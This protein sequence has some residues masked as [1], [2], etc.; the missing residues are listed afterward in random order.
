MQVP[1]LPV[2]RGAVH[3]QYR[4]MQQWDASEFF[5]FW[6]EQARGVEREAGR[7]AHAW[8]HGVLERGGGAGATHW[9]RICT[10]VVE[11]RRQCLGCQRCRVRHEAAEMFSVRPGPAGA[12][13]L[14]TSEMYLRECGPRETQE[15]DRVECDVCQSRQLHREQTRICVAPNVLVLRVVRSVEGGVGGVLARGPVDVEEEMQLPGFPRMVLA[16]V[17]YHSGRTVC[18]GHYTCL[19]RGPGGHYWMYDDRRVT[20]VA[21]EVGHVKSAQVHL[22]VY[23]RADGSATWEGSRSGGHGAGAPGDPEGGVVVV[24]DDVGGGSGAGVA[25]Q[26]GRTARDGT[27]DVAEVMESEIARGGA[28]VVQRRASGGG[29][30]A[31]AVAGRQGGFS[32]ASVSAV[33]SRVCGHGEHGARPGSAEGGGARSDAGLGRARGSAVWKRGRDADPVQEPRRASARL[34]ARQATGPVA[35]EVGGVDRFLRPRGRAVVTSAASRAFVGG[36]CAPC[37]DRIRPGENRG[38]EPACARARGGAGQARIAA[39]G[40]GGAG[41][42]GGHAGE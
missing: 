35:A 11:Y 20:Q 8:G 29:L 15:S 42:R 30:Q 5:G 28:P 34:A 40:G 21:G 12:A 19:C 7:C 9:D 2:A 18:S 31:S 27:G 6:F 17:V 39:H 33:A 38:F 16:G 41:P 32:D 13:P 23:V 36:P 26:G 1:A 22:M 37:S 10:S 4:N 3:E 14:T 25:A 24:E